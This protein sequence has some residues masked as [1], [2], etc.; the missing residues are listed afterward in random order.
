LINS[1]GQLRRKIITRT[2]WILSLVSLLTDI[3][4][5]MLY[6]VIPVYIKSIGYSVLFIG[7]LEGIAEATAGLSKGFFGKW[8]DTSG[9]RVP[10]IRGGYSLSAIAKPLMALI[11]NP[12]WILF[13][14][15]L[16]RLGKGIR[17]AA[18]DA[19]LSSEST[20]ETKARVFGF[21]R[22][23]DTTG[24]FIGPVFAL[25]FLYF[26]PGNFILLFYF[27]IIP[28]IAAILFSG[29][30]KEKS[31]QENSSKKIPSFVSFIK[32]YK[33]SSPEYKKLTIALLV[34]AFFNSSDMLLILKAKESTGSETTAIFAYILYNFVYAV[35]SYPLGLW[36]D[37]TDKKTVFVFGLILF[38]VSYVMISFSINFL[39]IIITF[40]V[41]GFYISSTEGISKAWISSLVKK[42]ETATAIG[43]LTAFQSVGVLISSSLAGF[44]WFTF[45]DKA[46][47]LTTASASFLLIFYFIFCVKKPK[48]I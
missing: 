6:P 3:A 34:F 47:F 38:T 29:L 27:A 7:I 30:L 32:Y 48:T 13:T 46:A 26:Y 8:S 16:D 42:E 23:L 45:G 37:R 25:I 33:T 11:P 44:L 15:T 41:Y 5:E 43:F 17:T 2:I 4:S 40:S 31:T 35:S 22:S 28:G 36:A 1:S 39:W 20:P 14:R 24:A 19:V 10:F 18:R 9:R 21:H 12:V